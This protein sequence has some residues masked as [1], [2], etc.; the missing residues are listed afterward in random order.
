MGVSSSAL[1]AVGV[2]VAVAV[3][4]ELGVDW[5]VGTVF[6]EAESTG[7]GREWRTEG[8]EGRDDSVLDVG[9]S[10][11]EVV[12]TRGAGWRALVPDAPPEACM[13]AVVG[14]CCGA[15]CEGGGGGGRELRFA[16][17]GG[18]RWS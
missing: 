4:R 9:A 14:R 8:K 11:A 10:D 12:A 17:G 5:S 2:A 16:W 15:P 7:W 18:G 1:L 13:G 6:D 3:E